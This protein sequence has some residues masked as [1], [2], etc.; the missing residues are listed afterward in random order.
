MANVQNYT[1]KKGEDAIAAQ[2]R[3]KAQTKKASEQL[4]TAGGA[5]LGTAAFAHVTG[6]FPRLESIDSGGKLQTAWILGPLMILGGM[7]SK[8]TTVFGAGIGISCAAID[9][10]V[11]NQSWAQP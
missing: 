8:T 4:G 9:R 1:R 11:T 3:Q 2:D 7:G 6:K 10:Y 5:L